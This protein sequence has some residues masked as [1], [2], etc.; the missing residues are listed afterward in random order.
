MLYNSES[1]SDSYLVFMADLLLCIPAPRSAFAPVSNSSL[2]IASCLFFS[3]HNSGV[4]PLLSFEL[5][6]TRS[7]ASSSL[8]TAS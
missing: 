6:S 5:G 4:W 1:P 3:A 2:T 8:T 7:V